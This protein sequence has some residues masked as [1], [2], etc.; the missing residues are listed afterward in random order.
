MV[1]LRSWLADSFSR[2]PPRSL[3]DTQRHRRQQP[4]VAVGSARQ[5]SAVPSVCRAC[6]VLCVLCDFLG[7][8]LGIHCA[9]RWSDCS[10]DCILLSWPTSSNAAK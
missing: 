1:R 8:S 4:V 9:M 5:W 7:T 6:V 10:A 2:I 3:C